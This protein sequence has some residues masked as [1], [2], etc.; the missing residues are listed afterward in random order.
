MKTKLSVERKGT[1]VTSPFRR[2]LA[3][4][5]AAVMLCVGTFMFI[6]ALALAIILAPIWVPLHFVLRSFGRRGFWVT[7]GKLIRFFFTADSFRRR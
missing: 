5:I 6:L 3:A 4:V 1:E 2:M 7:E